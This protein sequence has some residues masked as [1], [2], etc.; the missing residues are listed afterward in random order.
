MGRIRRGLYE[1]LDAAGWARPGMSPV[2]RLVAGAITLA[3]LMAVLET[4]GE[5]RAANAKLFENADLVFGLLFSVEYSLRLWAAGENP[6]YRGVGGRIR[7]ALSPFALIDLLAILPFLLTVGLQDAFLLRIFRLL[8]LF[9]LARLGRYSSALQNIFSALKERRYELLMSLAA[10]FVV[11]LLAA[12]A[13]HFTEGSTNPES[14]GSIP[15]ALWWGA[16][17]VT[18][19]GYGNAFPVTVLGRVFAVVFAIA[20]VAVVAMP[21]GI[22]AAAFSDAFRRERE[23]RTAALKGE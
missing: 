23:R 13:L 9:S 18:K 4:E 12:S 22:L 8:R 7:Y 1:Q 19:V 10:A 20:A 3:V 6:R 21:T 11:M 15:R 5:L 14:F 2:N 16:A 17:T